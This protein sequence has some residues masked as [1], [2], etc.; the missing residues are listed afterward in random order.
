MW[1]L[2]WIGGRSTRLEWWIIHVG[3]LI[4]LR[5]L[6]EVYLAAHRA[7]IGMSGLPY[8]AWVGFVLLLLWLS[9]ASILRRLHA[10]NKSGWWSLPYLVPFLGWGWMYIECGFLKDRAPP[11]PPAHTTVQRLAPP[12]LTWRG[13]AKL[14]GVSA[15]LVLFAL[16]LRAW[17]GFGEPAQVGSFKDVTGAQEAQQTGIE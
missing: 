12:R 5:I 2:L 8:L 1:Q 15:A 13:A 6:G 16:F 17:T 10:R 11:A 7:G 14:A 4:A 3:V 9:F